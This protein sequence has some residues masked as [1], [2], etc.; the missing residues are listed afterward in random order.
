MS[1]YP[2]LVEL[3]RVISVAVAM[4]LVVAGAILLT[5]SSQSPPAA[6]QSAIFFAIAAGLGWA[7][8]SRGR[9]S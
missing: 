8:K 9:Y 5:H 1:W 4:F 7:T 3:V 6:L 2:K